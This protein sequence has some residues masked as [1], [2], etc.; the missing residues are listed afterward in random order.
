[1]PT[2]PKL[3]DVRLAMLK[4]RGVPFEKAAGTCMLKIF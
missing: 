1:M 4:D 2:R 3:D